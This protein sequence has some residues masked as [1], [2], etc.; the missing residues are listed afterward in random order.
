MAIVQTRRSLL[1][2]LGAG[3][4]AAP[5]VVRAA[6]LMPV[7][8]PGLRFITMEDY[9][10][11]VLVPAAERFRREREA[12]Y[13]NLSAAIETGDETL[14][15]PLDPIGAAL[16]RA[17]VV[18]EIFVGASGFVEWRMPDHVVDVVDQ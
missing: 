16:L 5:A 6:S 12:F 7:R 17:G 14:I 9:L 11:R 1:I 15:R 18:K 10:R 4:I 2:G 8:A 3:L 13:R